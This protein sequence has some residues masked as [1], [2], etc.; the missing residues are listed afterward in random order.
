MSEYS[1]EEMKA[2][3]KGWR[4]PDAP[5][6][7]KSSFAAPAGS[8]SSTKPLMPYDEWRALGAEKAAEYLARRRGYSAERQGKLWAVLEWAWGETTEN[9]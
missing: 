5:V 4:P 6:E 1:E 8:P 3:L 7:A 2:M 9:H